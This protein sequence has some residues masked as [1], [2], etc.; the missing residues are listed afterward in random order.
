MR[1]AC[2]RPVCI[3][4]CMN[5]YV[6][7]YN[8]C[9]YVCMHV[10]R[11]DVRTYV[12]VSAYTCVLLIHDKHRRFITERVSVYIFAQANVANKALTSF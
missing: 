5:V 4:A 6:G 2:V 1:R 10:C 3:H 11:K 7:P 8:V 9:V 12:C